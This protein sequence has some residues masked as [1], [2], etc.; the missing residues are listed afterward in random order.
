[1]TN[2][3][4]WWQL[5]TGMIS[6]SMLICFAF[7][8]LPLAGAESGQ[9]G[10]NTV[11][12]TVTVGHTNPT[13]NHPEATISPS[14][15]DQSDYHV[16]AT[17]ADLLSET[18]TSETFSPSPSQD[19]FSSPSAEPTPDATVSPDIT[20]QLTPTPSETV[21]ND[22]PTAEAV[23][24]KALYM[25]GPTTAGEGERISLTLVLSIQNAS[26][27][28]LL[29]FGVRVN[30]SS[31]GSVSSVS[32]THS[33]SV[34]FQNGL[35]WVEDAVSK[36]GAAAVQGDTL[37]F[38]VSCV[39]FPAGKEAES[40]ILQLTLVDASGHTVDLKDGNVDG[41]L[42]QTEYPIRR[43][44]LSA[45]PADSEGM[46]AQ[47]EQDNAA[48]PQDTA[49]PENPDMPGSVTAA[50]AGDVPEVTPDPTETLTGDQP[51]GEDV[52]SET[53]TP[54]APPSSLDETEMTEPAVSDAPAPGQE[55]S[56]EP[57]ETVTPEPTPE[58]TPVT[59]RLA[60][61]ASIPYDQ[62]HIGDTLLLTA[63]VIGYDGLNVALQWQQRIDGEWMNVQGATDATLAVL[64]SEENLNSAWRY[65][66]AVEP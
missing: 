20:A 13:A 38:V 48:L 27:R 2:M 7:T 52:P 6:I 64:I 31:G 56:L 61:S 46:A 47:P 22:L 42:I 65:N 57:V 39:P 49:M 54:D 50:P 23:Q 19:A 33:D 35:L 17:E 9:Q 43:S 58:P 28:S 1:M 62:L 14:G 16:T 34:T 63:E 60:I 24:V 51:Q 5:R 40:V 30:I 66:I 32:M 21:T 4:K 18:G 45:D 8:C 11:E 26:G 55:T 15:D 37:R 44:Q 25:K 3:K 29:P 12:P 10:S 36:G 41:Q 59:R 53:P